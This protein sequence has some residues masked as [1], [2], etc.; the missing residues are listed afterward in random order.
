MTKS[1]RITRRFEWNFE[2]VEIMEKVKSCK[3]LGIAAMLGVMVQALPSEA[4][5]KTLEQALI[6]KLNATG[7][8]GKII[9]GA[10]GYK[11]IGLKFKGTVQTNGIKFRM[12]S[13][14]PVTPL[15]LQ[16]QNMSN[17]NSQIST[18]Q[19]S[20]NESTSNSEKFSWSTSATLGQS[21]SV[22]VKSPLFGGGSATTSFEVTQNVGKATTRKRTI[23]WKN[24]VSVPVGPMQAIQIQFVVSEKKLN[25]PWSTDVLVSGPVKITYRRAPFIKVCL[26]EHPNYEGDSYCATATSNRDFPNFKSLRFSRGGK[27]NDKVSSAREWGDGYVDL[28]S[29]TK[30]RKYVRRANRPRYGRT[31][32][33]FSSMQMRPKSSTIEK[34]VNIQDYLSPADLGIRIS[35]QY[36]GVNGVQGDFRTSMPVKLTAADCAFGANAKSMPAGAGG[37]ASMPSPGAVAAA[38]MMAAGADGLASTPSPGA[39][40][41][42]AKKAVSIVQVAKQKA[43]SSKPIAVFKK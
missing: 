31:D 39:V 11:I 2:R 37:L 9:N 19:A 1:H 6:E 30:F 17:C 10:S 8:A 14:V 33:A 27:M 18:L 16:Q 42:M 35:G 43:F 7:A 23:G 28:F 26:Y 4:E 22:S 12:P 5:A 20:V 38:M 29:D 32:D 41:K 40:R 36:N 34:T 3:A 25:V 15:V 21:V 13:A 24:G